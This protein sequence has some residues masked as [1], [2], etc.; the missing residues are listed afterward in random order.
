MVFMQRSQ[1]MKAFILAAGIGSRLRPLTD[2][3]PKPLIPVFGKPIIVY[4]LEKLKDNGF[5]EV[6]IN[7]H[8]LKAQMQQTLGDGSKYGIKIVWQVEEELLNTGGS[9]MQA[10]Q[11]LNCDNLLLLNADILCNIDLEKFIAETNTGTNS[12][13]VL[14]PSIKHKVKPDFSYNYGVVQ[15][16]TEGEQY[17]YAGIANIY[18]PD[19]IK[20]K[21]STTKFALLEWFEYKLKTKPFNA[22]VHKGIWC[23]IGTEESLYELGN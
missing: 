22:L 6:L 4:W 8:H 20:F 10:C 5:D 1:N 7:C 11:T 3:I 15:P 9:L 18:C 23:D 19:F 14:V 12:S 17:T 16:L 21:P 2:T 13:L